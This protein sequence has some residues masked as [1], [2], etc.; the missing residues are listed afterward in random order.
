MRTSVFGEAL[1]IFL[2]ASIP[3]KSG[4]LISRTATR[5]KASLL[6]PPPL[7]LFV[8]HHR[9]STLDEIPVAS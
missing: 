9:Q 1:R 5:A 6:S 7:G 4:I 8:P 2:A 3:F